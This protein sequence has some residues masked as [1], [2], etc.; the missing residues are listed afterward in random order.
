MEGTLPGQ[1]RGLELKQSLWKSK[2]V[3]IGSDM[4]ILPVKIE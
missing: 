4:G 2:L 1:I 3:T